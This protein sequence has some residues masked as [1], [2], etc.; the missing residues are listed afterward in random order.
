MPRASPA[1][2]IQA[3]RT[4]VERIFV[5]KLDAGAQPGALVG[6][7]EHVISGRQFDFGN[8]RQ[9]MAALRQAGAPRRAGN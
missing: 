1:T 4:A 3:D 9:L 6:T 5:L 8:A 7:L 2:P